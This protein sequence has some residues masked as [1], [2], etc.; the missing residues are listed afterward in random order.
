MLLVPI[1]PPDGTLGVSNRPY[2]KRWACSGGYWRGGL[3]GITLRLNGQRTQEHSV[4]S[5]SPPADRFAVRSPLSADSL[6]ARLPPLSHPISSLSYSLT[7]SLLSPCS[8]PQSHPSLSTYLSPVSPPAGERETEALVG[9][10]RRL[11]LWVGREE[12]SEAPGGER[13]DR[14][15]RRGEED[16]A[17]ETPPRGPSLSRFSP[18]SHPSLSSSLSLTRVSPMSYPLSPPL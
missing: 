17:G 18:L 16:W 13:R 9:E 2:V 14:G 12:G 15:S 4:I 1:V 7:L 3:F 10:K 11:R 6:A 5:A 8:H